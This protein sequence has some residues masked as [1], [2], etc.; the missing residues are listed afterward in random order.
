MVFFN[1]KGKKIFYKIKNAES[2][3]FLLFI[4]GSGGDSTIWKHQ[5]EIDNNYSLI[6]LDLPSHNRSDIFETLY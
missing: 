2:K 6:A 1:Y 4:H 5:F 3:N